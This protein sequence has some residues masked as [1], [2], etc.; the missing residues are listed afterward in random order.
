MN[1]FQVLL[2]NFNLRHY[3]VAVGEEVFMSYGAKSN[4][5]LLLIFG[6]A[7]RGTPFDDVPLSLELPAVEVAVVSAA[8]EA[9]LARGAA[10]LTLSPH[11][12]RAEG[13]GGAQRLPTTGSRALLDRSCPSSG[14]STVALLVR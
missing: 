1:C 10:N 5:E 2:S 7:L 14:T 6:F 4:A 9:A 12:V 3:T 11:A 13:G 8:R